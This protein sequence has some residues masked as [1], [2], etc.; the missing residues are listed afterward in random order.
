[1]TEIITLA[2]R[3]SIPGTIGAESVAPDRLATLSNREIAAL[4]VWVGKKSVPLGEVF[5]VQGERSAD[6]RVVGALGQVEGLGDG[7][8]GGTLVIDGPAGRGVGVQM[9]GGTID[10]RGDVGAN[11]ALAMSGG[12]LRVAGNAGD[13][14]GGPRH[15]GSRGMTG[16]E[17]LVRGN[18]GAD[19]GL[20]VRRGL[21]VIGGDAGPGAA[22]AMI[23]GTLV[24]FGQ[25]ASGAGAWSKR[26]TVI[27][28]GGITIPATYRLA[29]TYRPPIIRILFRYLRQTYQLPVDDRYVAGL[30]TR[31]AGDLADLGKGEILQW[32]ST[33]D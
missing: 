19:A 15:G 11:A 33:S 17:I 24:V 20:R 10:A 29:C 14:L 5:D 18:A 27:A 7:M 9:T 23:A 4:P 6:V 3:N 26:G 22:R 1:M 8:A 21:L 13:R 16:G 32:T 2:L 30:Y 31:Y 25:A 28:L 12:T